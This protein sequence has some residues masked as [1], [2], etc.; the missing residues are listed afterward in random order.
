MGS[1][2]ENP[3]LTITPSPGQVQCLL[4]PRLLV[5]A[6]GGKVNGVEDYI[7]FSSLLHITSPSL[8]VAH[9]LGVVMGVDNVTSS[10]SSLSPSASVLVIIGSS[11]SFVSGTAPPLASEGTIDVSAAAASCP[12]LLPSGYPPYTDPQ[13]GRGADA[14]GTAS[15]MGAAGAGARRL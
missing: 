2:C 9:E 11:T 5:L 8:L 6:R 15:H 14:A 7:I 12:S 1:K 4:A 3:M 13:P 10:F